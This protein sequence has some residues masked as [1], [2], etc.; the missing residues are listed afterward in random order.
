[1]DR[2]LKLHKMFEDI[3]GSKAVYFQPPKN[4]RM[5]Y[6]CI[7]YKISGIDTHRADDTLH[8][9]TVKYQVTYIDRNPDNSVIF[10]LIKIPM[11]SLDRAY[12]SDGLHH[13]VYDLYF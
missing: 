9:N 8:I 4:L 6:P 2:R 1:M 5:T 11:I 12:T 13:Y 3:L 7:R 10:R